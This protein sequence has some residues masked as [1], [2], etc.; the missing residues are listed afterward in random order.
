VAALVAAT[1]ALGAPSSAAAPHQAEGARAIAPIQR[2]G[3]WD[4]TTFVPVNAASIPPG[5]VHLLVHGWAPGARPEV[6]QH[7]GNE[8]LLAWDARQANGDYYF[9]WLRPLASAVAARDP[10]AVIL[11]YSWIDDSATSDD[12]LEARV[13]ER[14]TGRNGRRLARGLRAALAPGFTRQGGLLHFVGHSHGA[15]VVTVGAAELP[16]PP[17]HLTLLDSPDTAVPDLGGAANNLP[18]L[19]RR[20]PIGRTPGRVFVDNYFSLAG[21]RYGTDRNLSVIVNVQLDPA[22]LS[23]ADV[24]GRHEYP[25]AWYTASAQQPQSGVGLDWSPLLGTAY[26]QLASFYVEA[27][28]GDPAGELVLAP[29]STGL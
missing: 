26:E 2:L 11:A 13:S 5:H 16:A 12:P 1:A 18:P 22:Q 27:H 10:G 8:P 20:L 4:G 6:E 15:R 7:Q 17:A 28:P 24:F 3:R 14:R 29:A 21:R 23:E 19:L 25:I 9:A